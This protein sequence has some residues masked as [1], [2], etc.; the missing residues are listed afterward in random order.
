MPTTSRKPHGLKAAEVGAA[1]SSFVT[2]C[3]HV[4]DFQSQSRT[5]WSFNPV[6]AIKVPSG[7]MATDITESSH[8]IVFRHL[9]EANAHSRSV[10][11]RPPESTRVLSR[12]ATGA[13]YHP[14][15]RH[16]TV[17]GR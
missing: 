3:K 15:S 9:L 7:E 11:S 5:V 12:N 13:F 6:E 1:S 17:G 2:T 10:L 8:S 14:L 4:P 16:N